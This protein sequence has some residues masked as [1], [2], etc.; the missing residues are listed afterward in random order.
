MHINPGPGDD[1]ELRA[2]LIL[3]ISLFIESSSSFLEELIRLRISANVML[4][5]GLELDLVLLVFGVFIMK[6]MK[7]K[8]GKKERKKGK[9][10]I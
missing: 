2:W 7:K 5:F 10:Q 8:K 4:V 9:K 6:E 1:E 3:F